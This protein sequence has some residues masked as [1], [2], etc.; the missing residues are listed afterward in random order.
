[1]STED[2]VRSHV[3]DF[4]VS[5]PFEYLEPKQA[6]KFSVREQ[7]QGDITSNK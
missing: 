5:R 4:E 6:A 2:V 3:L 7:E 1:V